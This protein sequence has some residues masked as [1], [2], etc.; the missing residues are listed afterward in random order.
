MGLGSMAISYGPGCKPT[1]AL[2]HT[3]PGT[4]T[5]TETGSPFIPRTCD[6]APTAS[7]SNSLDVERNPGVYQVCTE[8]P[9][10]DEACASNTELNVFSLLNYEL[11]S[12]SDPSF[13][14]WYGSEICGPEESITDACCYVMDISVICE[15]RP[16]I[17]D[18]E[19]RVAPH[20]EREDWRTFVSLQTDTLSATQR[21]QLVQRWLAAAQ[22]EHASIASFSRFSLDL[23]SLGAPPEFLA[24]C[25]RAMG[26][27]IAHARSCY[28]VPSA[29]A[30]KPLGPDALSTAS[31]HTRNPTASEVLIATIVEGCI[32]E[33]LAAAEA[34][35]AR[36]ATHNP[37][38]RALLDR[39]AQDET[40]HAALA[41]RVVQWLLQR[42]PELRGLAVKAFAQNAPL[43]P[44]DPVDLDDLW[45]RGMGL[46]PRHDRLLSARRTWQAVIR[47]CA[48]ALF[49]DSRNMHRDATLEPRS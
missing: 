40:R 15:G 33:T 27:E 22:A 5:G 28:G 36:D 1:Q 47:P 18:G 11:G 13:C 38:L 24:G 45:M 29:L 43:Q 17:V 14:G 21:A 44:I 23:M 48:N 3:N 25:A 32:N 19:S 35:E 46:L 41:W 6:E 10:N 16:F 31:T 26:D 42:H 12:T 4:E 20:C 8:L 9:A 39:I 2:V 49:E 34:A 30:D 7:A 37:E